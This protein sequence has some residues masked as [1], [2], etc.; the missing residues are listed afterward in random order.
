MNRWSNALRTLFALLAT[1]VLLAGCGGGGSSPPPDTS[2]YVPTPAPTPTPPPT[3]APTPVPV[4]PTTPPPTAGPS[5]TATPNAP[6]NQNRITTLTDYAGTPAQSVGVAVLDSGINPTHQEFTANSGLNGV[7]GPIVSGGINTNAAMNNAYPSITGTSAPQDTTNY[8]YASG[9]SN[10]GNFVAS[11]IGGNNVGYTGDASLYIEKITTTDTADTATI[12]YGFGDAASKGMSFANLSYGLDPI[13]YY[14]QLADQVAAERAAGQTGI[15]NLT[16]VQY[17]QYQNVIS[18]GMGLVVSAGNTGTS[19][20][21]THNTSNTW[22]ASNPLYG[23]TL[24]V[25]ALDSTQKALASY[26]N[27]AGDDP[28]VQKRFLVAPGTNVGA[29]PSSDTAYGNFSGTSSAAPVVTAA[30]ATLKSYWSFMTPTQVAQRLLDTADKNFNAQWGIDTCGVLGNLNCGSYY[31][32]QGRLDLPAAMQPAG[33]V[34]TTTAASVPTS[35][36]AQSAPAAT[37][38]LTVPAALAPIQQQVRAESVGIQGF[39]AIGRNYTLDLAPAINSVTDPTQ[40]LGYQMQGF[41]TDF[42]DRGRSAFHAFENR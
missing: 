30:A 24:I 9:E 22:S 19:F 37:T 10:H 16:D 4:S 6:V 23:L 26:S 21:A 28:N 39:D 1:T 40:T 34:V 13:G 18:H 20:S 32:G 36:S 11:I 41:M 2:S 27:Y 33:V 17:A 14:Q 35:A 25:G 5:P 7:G 12:A 15:N 8:L 38:G 31:F 3:P 42:M 29:D